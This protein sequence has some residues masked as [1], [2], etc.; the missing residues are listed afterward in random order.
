MTV[1]KLYVTEGIRHQSKNESITYKITTTNW[2][3]SPTNISATAVIKDTGL[4]IT[5]T[6]FPTNSPSADGDVISL[7]PLKNLWSGNEYIISVLFDGDGNTY[8]CFFEIDC[9]DYRG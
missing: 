7:S 5:E 4:D 1:T 8:E 6:V 3:S 2:V 9:V